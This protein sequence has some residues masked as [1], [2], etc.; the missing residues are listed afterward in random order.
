MTMSIKLQKTISMRE[1]ICS[2][3]LMAICQIDDETQCS[4]LYLN[5]TLCPE[6]DVKEKYSESL[7]I[8][9]LGEK[10]KAFRF[11]GFVMT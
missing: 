1:E 6:V 9:E 5:L 10:K 2:M 7:Q 3:N 4:M 11:Q 8:N